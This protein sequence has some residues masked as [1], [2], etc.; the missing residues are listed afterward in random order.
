MADVSKEGALF[1]RDIVHL[2]DRP[3]PPSARGCGALPHAPR[4]P[5]GPAAGAVAQCERRAAPRRRSHVDVEQDGLAD[6]VDLRDDA[7]EV[8]RFGE[9][10]LEDLLHVDARRGR[11]ED[12]ARVHRLREPP[13]LLRDLFLLVPRECCER[14]VLRPYQEWDCCLR[15]CRA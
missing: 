11:A 4:S 5:T 12:E 13:R 2:V 6:A 3:C 1:Q 8:E 7:L 10:D 15:E 9:D 14:V